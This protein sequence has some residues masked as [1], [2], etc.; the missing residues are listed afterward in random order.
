MTGPRV[1]LAS[2]SPRRRE[3]LAVAG[4]AF[5]V[6]PA[7]IDESDVPAHAT[8]EDIARH[9]AT[10]KANVVAERHPDA[11]VLGAD[12]VVVARGRLLGKPADRADA[13]RMIRL[14]SGSAHEVVTGVCV[15]SPHYNGSGSFTTVVTFRRLTEPEVAAHLDADHWRGKAGGY[16]LQDRDP[17]VTRVDGSDTNV[18]GLPMELVLPM[19]RDA[20]VRC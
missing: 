13:E 18:V 9:L 8:A 17:F 14:L 12:T 6:D 3:L 10:A 20:G 1:I 19:L 15:A 7:D 4:V 11:V 5:E 2:A 16:G